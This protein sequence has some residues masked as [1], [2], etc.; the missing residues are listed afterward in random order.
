MASSDRTTVVSG[1]LLSEERGGKQYNFSATVVEVL[2]LG[3]Q[4]FIHTFV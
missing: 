2:S 4:G 3:L 1:R